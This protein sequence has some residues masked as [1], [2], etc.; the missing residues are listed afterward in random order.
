MNDEIISFV[1]ETFQVFFGYNLFLRNGM[2]LKALFAA[3]FRGYA[4]INILGMLEI[5][6]IFEK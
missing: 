3:D 1:S 5:W 2:Q 4:R 6:K